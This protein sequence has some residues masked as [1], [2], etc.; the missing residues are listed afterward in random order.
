M[1]YANQQKNVDIH[2]IDGDWQNNSEQN[3]QALYRSCHMK[4]HREKKLC[5]ICGKPQKG[6]GYC[7]KHYIRFKKH[8]NPLFTKNKVSE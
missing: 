3:L 2:H 5:I 6:L 8:V 4:S 7:N 1:K